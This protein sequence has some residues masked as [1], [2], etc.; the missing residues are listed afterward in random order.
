MAIGA[1]RP[2]ASN[3]AG[4]VAAN[5]TSF[6]L[7]AEMGS[8]TNGVLQNEYLHAGAAR[9]VSYDLEVDLSGG[10]YAY[11]ED[12]LMERSA[13]GGAEMHHTDQNTLQ[14]A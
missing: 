3:A 5:A 8:A 14:K 11:K 7:R 6:S 4:S 10:N 2:A 9:T 1:T 13:H 12:T